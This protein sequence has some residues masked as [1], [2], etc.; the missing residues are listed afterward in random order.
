MHTLGPLLNPGTSSN[1]DHY[2][3]PRAGLC[4]NLP[5]QP[6]P[7]TAFFAK[8]PFSDVRT[9]VAYLL[10]IKKIMISKVNTILRIHTAF[11]VF[12]IDGL[13]E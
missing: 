1:G 13:G 4:S 8:P 3:E 2:R 9:I 5:M 7:E 6:G 11:K 12:P 10:V